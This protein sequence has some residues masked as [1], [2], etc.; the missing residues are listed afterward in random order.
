MLLMGADEMLLSRAPLSQNQ[1]HLGSF[2]GFQRLRYYRAIRPSS[3]E[4]EVAV[5]QGGYLELQ[6][7]SGKGAFSLLRFSASPEFPS[8][9]F[10]GKD[11][12]KL[13]LL[14]SLPEI[15]EGTW[16][17]LKF[18][19]RENRWIAS[20]NS[21]QW[22]A[23]EGLAPP[24]GQMTL[25]TGSRGVDIR[26]VQIGEGSATTLETFE[27]SRDFPR[28]FLFFLCVLT[29]LSLV[30]AKRSSKPVFAAVL[31]SGIFF[32][33]GVGY[34]SFDYFYWSKKEV[35][36][37]TRSWSSDFRSRLDLTVEA[38]R[39]E[40][41]QGLGR[42]MSYG[43][44]DLRSVIEA[45]YIPKR[46]IEGPFFCSSGGECSFGKVPPPSENHSARWMLVGTSQAMGAGAKN[47]SE[48]FFSKTHQLL[49]KEWKRPLEGLNISVSGSNGVDLF[50]RF[51]QKY[52]DFRPD[53]MV[54]NLSING[55]EPTLEAGLEKFLNWNQIRGIRTLLLKEAVDQENDGFKRRYEI[56]SR[57]ARK[58]Q[59]PTLDMHSYLFAPG[60][61]QSG[62]IWW[63]LIHL[64]NY[65]QTLV[66]EKLAPAILETW[67][68]ASKPG[69][70]GGVPPG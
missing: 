3:I 4:M 5:P 22:F 42:W 68:D 55:D 1:L 41:F 32:F 70:R 36:S 16:Q 24:H 60:V 51:Q 29:A 27:N 43:Y 37:L 25:G 58:Y 50:S 40:L 67:T 69:P 34:F 33:L 7:D 62:K 12:E 17:R 66:S 59:V 26:S 18:E 38:V 48:S 6:L 10:L 28:V 53:F 64:T 14:S 44:P 54:I 2:Y 46:Y 47:L 35:C 13:E 61:R 63:D 39:Y 15:P 52:Q 20:L 57:L 49:R 45:R 9:Y 21:K 11:S 31:A 30:L 19:F 8:G 56:I 23:L 65:G